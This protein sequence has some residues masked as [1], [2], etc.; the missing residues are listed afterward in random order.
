MS[1]YRAGASVFAVTT[2]SSNG[3]AQSIW[4]GRYWKMWKAMPLALAMNWSRRSF[5]RNTPS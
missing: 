3:R 5:S 1:W 4:L 2:A